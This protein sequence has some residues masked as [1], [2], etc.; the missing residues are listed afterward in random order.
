LQ[1]LSPALAQP[2][3]QLPAMPDPFGTAGTLGERARAYLHTNCSQCHRPGGGTPV[4]MDLR[5]TTPL[6]STNACE[7]VPQTDL[8]I[9]NARIIAI[10]GTNPA[11]RSMVVARSNRS[12]ANSMPPIQPRI[13]DSAGVALLTNWINGLASCN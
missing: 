2:V 12:D 9:S 1:M 13:I 5:Y 11:A 4:A 3:D 10:G 7:V 8:G 6:A